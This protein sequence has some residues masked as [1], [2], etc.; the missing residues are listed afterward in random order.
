[1]RLQAIEKALTAILLLAVPYANA[2]ELPTASSHWKIN[3]YHST[4]N[5]EAD[6][7][8]TWEQETILEAL[9]DAGAQAIGHYTKSF[10]R[11]LET[12]T[13]AEAYTL[14]ADGKKIAVES[15][16]I[17]IQT[18]VTAGGNG[19]SW[20]NVNVIKVT[21]PNVQKG[22]HTYVRFTGKEAKYPL[23]KWLVR[24]EYLDPFFTWDYF[25]YTVIAPKDS[26]IKL[27][28]SGLDVERTEKGDTTT[29]HVNGQ[30]S[31]RAID[32]RVANLQTS[33]PRLMISSI[34]KPEQLVEAYAAE[35]NKKLQVNAE[36]KEIASKII[37]GH[38][39]PFAKA[40]AIY[41]WMHHN[42]RYVASYI[43]QGGYV[44]HDLP[45]ILKNRYGD[46]KDHHLIF[47][48]LLQAAEIESAPALIHTG[49]A[50][51]ELLDLPVG[52]D[53]VITYIPSLKLFVDATAHQIPFGNL[54][55]VDADRPVAVALSSGAEQMRTPVAKADENTVRSQSI[56]SIKPDG[57]ADLE[58]DIQTTGYSATEM[59]NQL[60]DMPAGMS[61]SAIQ[62]ILKDSGWQGRGTAQ[63]PTPR[64]DALERSVKA[65]IEVRNLIPDPSGG[66]ISP[67]PRLALEIYATNNLGIH[68]QGKRD[69]ASICTPISVTE[70]FE[71]RF[72]SSYSIR[73]APKNI[74]IENPDGISFSARYE[75][76]GN[77]VKGSRKLVLGQP[78]HSCSKEQYAARLPTLEA[79]ARHLQSTVLF[80][81]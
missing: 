73:R 12:T 59:Q 51:F 3:R 28:A 64:Q 74:D 63:F 11:D 21:F 75:I 57:N 2:Q 26:P 65:H 8:N 29:W 17:Q 44:P 23:P 72:D 79:I 25:S 16:G 39:T 68:T 52:F 80:E 40:Q 42:F 53:H 5:I 19:A 76:Q 56:W 35:N 32:S 1:M 67:N 50:Q 47:Q 54:P 30:R 78:R 77:V 48:A 18:G 20:P 49:T 43:G 15:N 81:K 24:W 58:I 13:L 34:S 4:V 60:A 45:D 27:A 14:K 9:S 33:I 6:L 66:S 36:I 37:Q 7:S 22:D 61:A 41:N 69:F 71:L 10:N 46:C 38:S 55:W 62:K 70:D 31:A